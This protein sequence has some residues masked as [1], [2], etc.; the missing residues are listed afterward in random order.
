MSIAAPPD[1]AALTWKAEVRWG[2]SQVPWWWWEQIPRERWG[3]WDA[4]CSW[5]GWWTRGGWWWSQGGWRWGWCQDAFPGGSSTRAGD[6]EPGKRC[7]GGWKP[8][9]CLSPPTFEHRCLPCARTGCHPVLSPWAGTPASVC[10]AVSPLR[11]LVS[12]LG[13]I[14]V[15]FFCSRDTKCC[16]KPYCLSKPLCK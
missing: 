4:G 1:T 16:P 5:G 9:A 10:K 3:W 8:G 12:P 2:H 7:V 13:T 14:S 11:V 6:S 15:M